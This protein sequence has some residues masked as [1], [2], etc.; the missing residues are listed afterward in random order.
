M[1]L[2]LLHAQRNA[3]LLGIDLEHLGFDLL[4]HREHVGG[5]VDAAPGDLADMQQAVHAADVDEGAVV[6]QAADRAAH[7]FAFADL[8]VAAFFH[9]ALFFFGEGAAVDHYIFVGHIE[10][11]DAAADFL[12][13][14]LFHF[15]RVA[16]AAARGRHEGA[17]PNIHA[18]AAL[19][20]AG[21]RAHDGRF[22]GEGLLQRRPVLGLRDLL[23]GEF[24]VAF[25]IAAL[26]RNRHL[27]A[28]LHA[29]RRRSGTRPAA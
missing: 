11:D 15:G 4:A 1:R 10:L 28:G 5:L 3:P 23:A 21:D 18:E 27:V 24:V 2:Q 12:S 17:H 19:D 14:Q 29:S 8:G 6:G 7:G 16:Y 25:R 13:D 20:D 22:V 9:A 26:D